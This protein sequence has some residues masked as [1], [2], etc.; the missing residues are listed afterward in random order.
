MPKVL[1]LGVTYDEFW[2]LNPRIIEV[3]I[4]AQSE[5]VKNDIKYHNMLYHLQG[6]Y[7]ADALLATVG[8]MFSAK[9]SK[10]FEYPKEPHPLNL[11]M[12]EDLD[13]TNEADRKI[14]IER[15][16][17]V[18]QLNNMFGNIER[19]LEGRNADY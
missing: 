4:K 3:L 2:G 8:N 7:F 16:N 12:E 18:S 1:T 6:H 11:D 14:A 10:K 15:V 17:F 13:M 5:K 9:G 19:T